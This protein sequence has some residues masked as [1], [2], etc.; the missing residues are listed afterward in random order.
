MAS[1]AR[2]ARRLPVSSWTTLARVLPLLVIVRIALWSLPYR[3]V[4]RLFDSSVCTAGARTKESPRRTVALLRT[5][6]WAGRNLLADRPC[7]T[8][9]IACR[10]LLARRGHH[11][12]LK[13]GVRREEGGGIMAHAWLEMDGKIILGGWDSADVYVPF[14]PARDPG[15]GVVAEAAQ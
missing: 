13:L 5:V 10:W 14:H 12:D 9:A 4:T 3:V 7:L 6:A 8:Q 11:A 15:K 1:A 2:R